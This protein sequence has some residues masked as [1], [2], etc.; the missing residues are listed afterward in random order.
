MIGLLIIIILPFIFYY[1][2]IK[3]LNK[4]TTSIR[5]ALKEGNE[6]YIDPVDYKMRWTENGALV[7]KMKLNSL[8]KPGDQDSLPGDEVIIDL[9]TN[10]IYRNYSKEKFIAHVQ[11][12]INNNKCWCGER[13]EFRDRGCSKDYYMKYH[14]KEKYFY[15]LESNKTYETIYGKNGRSTNKHK[16]TIFCYKQIYNP[17]TRRYGDKIE[18]GY[19]EYQKLGGEEKIQD[20]IVRHMD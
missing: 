1:T 14:M 17:L 16:I 2:Q 10:K 19:T 7:R 12:Q 11:E 15:R 6:T 3:N 8:W 4:K 9:N 5:K 20:F 13:K 18:I